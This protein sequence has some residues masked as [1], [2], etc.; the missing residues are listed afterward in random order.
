MSITIST[1]TVGTPM[2]ANDVII[3]FSNNVTICARLVANIG[4]GTII[5]HN[6]KLVLIKKDKSCKVLCEGVSIR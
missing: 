3:T 6:G 2:C 1:V 5:L 4:E